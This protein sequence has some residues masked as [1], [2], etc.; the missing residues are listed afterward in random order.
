MQIWEDIYSIL[1]KLHTIIHRDIKRQ[2]HH[3][4]VLL[5]D[6]L[7]KYK[8]REVDMVNEHIKTLQE[9]YQEAYQGT[10]TI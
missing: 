1:E 6:T 2:A 4:Q 5:A 8:G 9:V 10:N 3:I 7:D